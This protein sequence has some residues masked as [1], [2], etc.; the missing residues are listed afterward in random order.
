MNQ[1]SRTRTL[2]A[3]VAAALLV[4][5]PVG[6]QDATVE[7]T[8]IWWQGAPV[9]LLPGES[10]PPAMGMGGMGITGSPPALNDHAQALMADFDPA[11][12]PA[13]RCEQPGLVR[14]VLSPYPVQVEHRGDTVS[15]RYEEWE[16]ERLVHL[17]TPPPDGAEP[18]PMGYSMG[19]LDQ[20]KLVVSTTGFTP[21]LNMSQGFFWT[22]DEASLLETYSLTDRG[23]LVMDMILTDPVMLSEPWRLQ[24]IWNPFDQELLTFDCILRERL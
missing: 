17:D 19:E 12:D 6:A 2:A 5:A 9:P 24:K 7:L 21:G 16:V 22:S 18:S 15:I 4:G 13:V 20:E 8:G 11:D 10:Q 23:Q 14:Q 1:L 3:G